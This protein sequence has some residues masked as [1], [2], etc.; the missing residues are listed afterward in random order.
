MQARER[1]STALRDRKTLT[2]GAVSHAAFLEN[3]P[4]DLSAHCD[5][6]E[7]RLD[8]LGTGPGVT[9]FAARSPLPLL[10]TA[11]GPEEGG[12][13]ALTPD[14]RREAYLKL[15]PHASAIDIEL[16]D[17]P[18]LADL[19][20][21]A[22][23]QNITI[24]GSFHDF[25][26]TPPAEELLA[27]SDQNADIFKVATRVHTSADIDTHVRLLA[28]APAASVMG[29]GPLGSASR[30]YLAALGSLL[31]YGFLGAHATAPG[32]WPA[33]LLKEALAACSAG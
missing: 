22:R 4:A 17:F 23:S 29:M 33:K 19:I 1:L 31:N 27:K 15:L 14:E 30:P 16:R 18:L 13:N 32:Q 11:R 10:I 25:E 24:I 28:A 8:S 6:V 2:V 12:E 3:P 21:T 26:K 5:L 9:N 7:L 20:E